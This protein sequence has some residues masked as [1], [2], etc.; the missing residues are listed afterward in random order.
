MARVLA[1]LVVCSVA[2]SACGE[3]AGPPAPPVSD[4]C[5]VTPAARLS[6]PD[7]GVPRGAL[8]F[9]RALAGPTRI[10]AAAGTKGELWAY[11]TTEPGFFV[12]LE[13]TRLDGRGRFEFEL[14]RAGTT[15]SLMPIDWPG[16]GVGYLYSQSQRVSAFTAKGCWR[17]RVVGGA[18]LDEIVVEAFARP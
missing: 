6:S 7:V 2:L 12:Q 18:P 4:Y 14:F 10:E 3:M 1:I 8:R 11:R 5:P 13:A 9:G 16:G 15:S 17:I